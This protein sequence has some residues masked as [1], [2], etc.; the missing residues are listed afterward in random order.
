MGRGGEGRGGEGMGAG[1][2]RKRE[3]SREDRREGGRWLGCCHNC[4]IA[5]EQVLQYGWSTSG[6]V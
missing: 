5:L 6:L 2:E 4:T 3:E 1:V